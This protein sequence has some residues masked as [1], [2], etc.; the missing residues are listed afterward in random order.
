[1]ALT[2]VFHLERAE[3]LYVSEVPYVSRHPT[4]ANYFTVDLAVIKEL[5]Q[6]LARLF[7]LTLPVSSRKMT[8]AMAMGQ[9]G[10][11]PHFT[12]SPGA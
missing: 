8:H 4:V 11:E 3:K 2:L 5:S 6:E 9:L 10:P 12:A 7:G 1:M